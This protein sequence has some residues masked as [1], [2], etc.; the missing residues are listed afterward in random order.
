MRIVLDT[1]VLVSGLLNPD[2]TPADGVR[3]VV[4]G[5][6]TLLLPA[7]FLAWFRR[8]RDRG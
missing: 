2:G 3:T 1:S 7:E 6:V 5:S 8:H 4:S